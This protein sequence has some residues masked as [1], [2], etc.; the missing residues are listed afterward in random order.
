MQTR[1]KEIIY[2]VLLIIE[3]LLLIAGYAAPNWWCVDDQSRV[4][5]DGIGFSIRDVPIGCVDDQ[6][7]SAWDGA[8]EGNTTVPKT[9][10]PNASESYYIDGEGDYPN[11][12][13]PRLKPR[14]GSDYF[15]DE[16]DYSDEV[17][18]YLNDRLS[19]YMWY[20]GDDAPSTL[21]DIVL[22]SLCG[23]NDIYPAR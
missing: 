20:A 14:L 3:S 16:V 18:D 5:V 6:N 2:I 21:D 19:R 17:V 9:E 10:K 22:I 12:R 23:Q 7:G 4:V 8:D 15:V 13:Y 1:T 11:D